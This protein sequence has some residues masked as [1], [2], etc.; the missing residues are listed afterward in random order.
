MY[1]ALGSRRSIDKKV[2]AIATAVVTASAAIGL[3]MAKSNAAESGLG[4]SG[5]NLTLNGKVYQYVS[6]N[7]YG[8][9]GQQTG[10]PYS[11]Q[12]DEEIF[13]SLP[14]NSLVR[15][16]AFKHNG[17]EG[18][19]RVVQAAEA[20][21]Q[22]VILSVSNG[23]SEDGQPRHGTAFFE[24]GY[25]EEL[26]PWVRELVIKY[27][28]SPAIGMWE[29]MNEPGNENA[30]DGDVSASAMKGF[31]DGVAAEIKKIDPDT[32]VESGTMD[33]KQKGMSDFG[34]LHSSPDI[35]VVSVHEYADQFEGGALISG[36]F[37][38]A[39]QQLKS[40][41]VNKPIIL[42]EVGVRGADGNCAHSRQERV[43]IMQQKIDRYLSSGAAG[44]NIWNY[45][46]TEQNEC[47]F[48]ESI[49]AGD[50]LVAAV[51]QLNV[52]G[53]GGAAVDDSKPTA[54]TKKPASTATTVAPDEDDESVVGDPGE[55]Q[56]DD[57]GV[58]SQASAEDNGD[59]GDN[60]I[61]ENSSVEDDATEDSAGD[62]ASD[63]STQED[64][65]ETTAPVQ[66]DPVR[67]ALPSGYV[68]DNDSDIKYQGKWRTEGG[69]GKVGGTDH[70]TYNKG[71]SATLSFTGTSVSLFGAKAPHH[72]KAQILIDGKAVGTVDSYS[73]TRQDNAKLFTSQALSKGKHT[74]SVVSMGTKNAKATDDVIAIDRFTVK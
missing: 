18:V 13:R 32:L 65:K 25:E 8:M 35:D 52:Q 36:N 67:S 7:A 11:S 23:A 57:G 1:S 40:A 53:R 4:V 66:D 68:D 43:G 45:F 54:T 31:F 9:T 17:M 62:V 60:G 55:D 61:D 46:N 33:P 28:D 5:S 42:G 48:G 29:I 22:M 63:V 64:T 16:W 51:K 69:A 70:Y 21:N 73:S 34:N 19:D 44:I 39:Q 30:T 47:D 3:F 27:K 49:H 37:T 38:S 71:D 58:D 6:F 2:V 59:D 15:T 56:G 74:I 24:G 14:P 20:T 12:D 26:L 72:G 10:T 50:P 41:G